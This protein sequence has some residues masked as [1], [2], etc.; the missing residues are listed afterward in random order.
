ML[1]YMQQTQTQTQTQSQSPEENSCVVVG[2]RWPS[3]AVQQ[4]QQQRRGLQ[5]TY[6]PL[7]W[8]MVDGGW[9]LGLRGTLIDIWQLAKN[10]W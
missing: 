10:M 1:I 4:Q 6:L 9:Q 2:D 8:G 3:E 5:L 7:G